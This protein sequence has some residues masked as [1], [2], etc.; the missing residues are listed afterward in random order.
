MKTSF[1]MYGDDTVKWEH[2]GKHYLLHVMND[3]DPI[4]PRD[5]DN[6]G[7]M[8]C[9]HQRYNLGDDIGKVSPEEFW[10]HLVCEHISALEIFEAARDGKL[11]GIRLEPDDESECWNIFETC[12]LAGWQ[13]RGEAKEYLEYSG[14]HYMMVSDYIMDDL[15]IGHCQTLL[16]PYI[17]YLDLYLYDHSGITM[18]CSDFGDRWDSGQVGWYVITKEEAMKNFGGINAEHWRER[19]REHI[20]GE[21]K[22]YNQWLAGDV[23]GFALYEYAPQEDADEIDEDDMDRIDSCWGFFGSDIL[24]NGIAEYCP[25]LQEAIAENRVEEGEATRHTTSYYSY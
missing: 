19:C 3:D 22:V 18:S 15:T 25:G 4:D 20:R 5:W 1:H 16:E 21:V 23:Y 24:E 9:F 17:E 11:T 2:D 13:T 12:Y 14:I 8:A 6:V 7:T 10:R